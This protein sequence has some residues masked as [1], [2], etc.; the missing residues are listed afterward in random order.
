MFVC[1]SSTD[2]MF[3][4]CRLGNELTKILNTGPCRNNN[5]WKKILDN[6]KLVS[7]IDQKGERDEKI[8]NSKT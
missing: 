5:G 8:Q 4:V 7:Y 1:S 3:P 6:G 2:L